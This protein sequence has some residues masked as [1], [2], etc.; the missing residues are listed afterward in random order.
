MGEIERRR[1]EDGAN[2]MK[3]TRSKTSG[4][5]RSARSKTGVMRSDDL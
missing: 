5:I 2:F 4:V 3:G 1:E